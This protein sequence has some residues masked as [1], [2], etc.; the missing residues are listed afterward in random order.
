M[1]I[2]KPPSGLVTVKGAP[3]VSLTSRMPKE[4][5]MQRVSQDS[6]RT[7]LN[8]GSTPWR[9]KLGKLEINWRKLKKNW[10]KT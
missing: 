2:T 5:R 3:D 1:S 8:L 4:E 9:V 7:G 10:K 6:N